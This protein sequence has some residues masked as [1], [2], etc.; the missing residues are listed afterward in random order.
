MSKSPSLHSTLFI[1]VQW[2]PHKQ[3]GLLFA[4]H[5][6]L[7]ILVLVTCR[8]NNIYMMSLHSTLFIL[9]LAIIPQIIPPRYSTF[10]SVY[11]STRICSILQISIYYIP[12]LSTPI[13]HS[14]YFL[15][16]F[17]SFFAASFFLYF[18]SLSFSYDI[19]IITGRQLQK[20]ARFI[21]LHANKF[22]FQPPFIT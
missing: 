19:F 12:I 10:H 18:L 5:S 14:Y 9:V 22:L 15:N 21:I 17:L 1:L 2:F 16:S 20:S 13:F 3:S 6:T 8:H 7:F 11:I 4:L